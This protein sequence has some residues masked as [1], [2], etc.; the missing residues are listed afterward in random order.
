LLGWLIAAWAALPLARPLARATVLDRLWRFAWV[1]SA[2]CLVAAAVIWI[3]SALGLTRLFVWRI[4]PFAQLACQLVVAV[5]VIAVVEQPARLHLVPGWRR[6]VLGVAVVAIV[7]QRHIVPPRE[8]YIVLGLA[9]LVVIA[10]RAL[11][12]A[13]RD[14]VPIVLAVAS[15][16]IAT[17]HRRAALFAPQTAARLDPMTLW[18]RR[19]TSVDAV[20]LTP[21]SLGH[22][23]LLARRAV[24]VDTWSPPLIPDELV[25]WYRR[26]CRVVDVPDAATHEEV[27]RRWA[28]V[29]GPRRLEIARSFG[30][31][32]LVVERTAPAITA[33]IA[34]DG[35]S[36]Y[37]VYRVE[38]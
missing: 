14:Y 35:D 15:C 22:F 8:A 23:R 9:A 7:A 36:Y 32:Y 34:F 24:I 17:G 18:A 12:A 10:A 29:P 11:P 38:R 1:A 33:P 5:A 25:A 4:G 6:I 21:P 28:D 37:L 13:V 27:E 31:D 2:M 16:A 20:F 3:P 26:L 30:A 19:A